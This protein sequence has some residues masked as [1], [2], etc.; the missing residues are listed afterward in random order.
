MQKFNVNTKR[1]YIDKQGNEKTV[2][3]TVGKI[4]IFDDGKPSLELFMFPDTKFMCFSDDRNQ[5]Q[6]QWQR[7]EARQALANFQDNSTY[8]DEQIPF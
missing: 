5:G 2:W 3:N 1:T 4:V 7:A 8:Q 6:L